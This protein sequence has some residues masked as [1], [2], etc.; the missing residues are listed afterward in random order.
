MFQFRKAHERSGTKLDWIESWHTFA[1]GNYCDPHCM[2]FRNLQITNEDRVM[3]GRG[4]EAQ[5]HREM[6]IIS[7]TRSGSLEHEDSL[8]TATV[9]RCG[10][11]QR[12]GA[13]TGV[14]LSKSNHDKSEDVY[15]LQNWIK[16]G[17]AWLPLLDL[18]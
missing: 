10:E 1:S 9:T 16:S 14:T 12:M 5:S 17:R 15:F 3:S 18:A 6:E 13:D 4:F 2:G 8:D 11:V 7:Y